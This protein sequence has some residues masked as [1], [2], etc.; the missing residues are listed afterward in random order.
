[1]NSF[2]DFQVIC[3]LCSEEQ[4]VQHNCIKCG[5]CMGKYFCALCK[6]FDDDVSICFV[7]ALCVMIYST[8][9]GFCF[10]LRSMFQCNEVVMVGRSQ[11]SSITVM[12]VESAGKACRSET[13]IGGE[14]NFFHCSSCCKI[15][16]L[17]LPCSSSHEPR[18]LC[19]IS[20]SH[21][22][23]LPGCCYS[24]IM[25]GTHRCL[26]NPMHHNCPVCC[27]VRLPID[28]PFAFLFSVHSLLSYL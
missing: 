18:Y 3:S 4:D 28:I 21:L 5:V 6:F 17:K 13:A 8:T 22:P 9:F 25:K 24:T 27:E 16:A 26:E 19:E 11:R 1:M 20:D 10:P 12:T 14:E 15:L 23:S 2:D 7:L